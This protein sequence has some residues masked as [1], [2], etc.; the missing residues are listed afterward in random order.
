MPVQ[1]LAATTALSVSNDA[2]EDDAVTVVGAVLRRF[3]GT[4]T[5]PLPNDAPAASQLVPF[6]TDMNITRTR[7][8]PVVV[9]GAVLCAVRVEPGSSTPVTASI[10]VMTSQDS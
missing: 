4:V 10:G 5:V 2:A 8:G 1:V 9:V 7:S 6:V 3:A